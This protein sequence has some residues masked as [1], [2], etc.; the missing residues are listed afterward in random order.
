MGAV[1]PHWTL[2]AQITVVKF[3]WNSKVKLEVS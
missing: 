1:M 2:A 3:W